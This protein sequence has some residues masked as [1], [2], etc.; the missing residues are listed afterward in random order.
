MEEEKIK[1]DNLIA[2]NS[3]SSWFQIFR[4]TYNLLFVLS[5]LISLLFLFQIILT[6]L[7]AFFSLFLNTSC[8]SFTPS[9]FHLL[10]FHFPL[11]Y[12]EVGSIQF[13]PICLRPIITPPSQSGCL[14]LL[15]FREG[16]YPSPVYFLLVPCI[17]SRLHSNPSVGVNAQFK[18]KPARS[19]IPFYFNMSRVDTNT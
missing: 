11:P 19:T 3:C 10:R 5:P 14:F 4:S 7:L 6:F 18:P 12:L 16:Y 2:S 13:T 17:L 8:C 15:F 1:F 9:N